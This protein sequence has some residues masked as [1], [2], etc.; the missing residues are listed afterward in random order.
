MEDLLGQILSALIVAFS[1]GIAVFVA[2]QIFR[3]IGKIKNEIV[4]QA[5]YQAVLWASGKFSEKQ[6]KAKFEAVMD[7]LQKKF[8]WLPAD[9][10]E[11]LI[12][13]TIEEIKRT[14]P[15]QVK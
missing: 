3:L 7:K 14:M 4:K 2:T 1:G 5:V 6:N 13:A 15:K 12:E 9:E 11:V 10:I 8:K